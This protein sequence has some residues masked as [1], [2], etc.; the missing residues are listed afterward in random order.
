[1]AVVCA[2]SP[3]SSVGD[4]GVGSRA[5]P[6]GPSQGGGPGHARTVS[7]I[8]LTPAL[9]RAALILREFR[10]RAQA[11]GPTAR[12]DGNTRIAMTGAD[13]HSMVARVSLALLRFQSGRPTTP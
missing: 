9:V 7:N 2:A 5:P 3:G 12:V 11:S 13:L 10:L 4:A 6:P 1:M 8:P